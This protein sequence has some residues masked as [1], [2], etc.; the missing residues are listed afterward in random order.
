MKKNFLFLMIMVMVAIVMAQSPE[1][2]SYQAIIRD[3]S[4]NLVRNAPVGV[5]VSILKNGSDGVS[6]YCETHQLTTNANGLLTMEIGGGTVV[7]GV[8]SAIDWGNGPY[9]IKTETD[10]TGGTNYTIIGAQQLLSVPYALYAKYAGNGGSGGTGDVFALADRVTQLERPLVYTSSVDEINYH[11][12]EVHGKVLSHGA[13]MVTAYG[14]CWST[15]P[16]PTLA[17][18]HTTNT[19]LE[20]GFYE[21]LTG[22]TPNTTYFVRTYATNSQGTAYGNELSFTMSG[23]ISIT[24]NGITWN[25]ADMKAVDYSDVGYLFVLVEKTTGCSSDNSDVYLYGSLASFVCQNATYQ[26]TGGDVIHY[27]DPNYIYTD[28][29]GSIGDAGSQY[30]GWNE[31]QNSFVET[32][33]AIDLNALT[34]SA[35]FTEEIFNIVD[36]INAGNQIPSNTYTL[37][38]VLNN[39]HWSWMSRSSVPVQRMDNPVIEPYID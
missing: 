32:V 14:V 31:V 20:D 36:Y 30:W 27:R 21:T 38:G 4:G 34:I 5:R 11:S 24:F 22:L 10:V 16:Q 28:V 19:N 9:F 8:F 2:F 6:V 26:S 35:T 39:A 25:A 29:N 18:N 23:L 33:T 15:S 1:K 13:S 17:D 37:T 7:E 3:A 12:A